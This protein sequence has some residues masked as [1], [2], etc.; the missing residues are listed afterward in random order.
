[1][2]GGSATVHLRIMIMRN[3]LHKMRRATIE[4]KLILYEK[5]MDREY[6]IATKRI[7]QLQ[8][9]YFNVAHVVVFIQPQ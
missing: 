8:L 4:L 5:F 9:F 1:M 2:N 3:N 6:K 7:L